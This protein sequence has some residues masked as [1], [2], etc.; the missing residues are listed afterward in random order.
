MLI[1]KLQSSFGIQWPFKFCKLPC[2]FQQSIWNIH[3]S[4]NSVTL[5]IV[6]KLKPFKENLNPTGRDTL[7]YQFTGK[8][9][10]SRHVLY[11]ITNLETVQC[12]FL[13]LAWSWLETETRQ[14]TQEEMVQ[15][16]LIMTKQLLQTLKSL[17]LH[18]YHLKIHQQFVLAYI[19]RR[20]LTWLLPV[21]KIQIIT[22]WG[23]FPGSTCKH[24]QG[25]KFK[26]MS[27]RKF[28]TSYENLV[29]TLKMLVAKLIEA[30]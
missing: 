23:Q 22:E 26:K 17:P 11:V 8:L 3:T 4:L 7:L 9:I 30:I 6:K 5:Q 18:I 14:M 16:G 27:G 21:K 12:T 19:H 20:K 13:L 1:T 24:N 10:L 29:A 2:S 25:S 28:A 15:Q